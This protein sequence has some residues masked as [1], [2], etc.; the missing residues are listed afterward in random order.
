MSRRSNAGSA[1]LFR[2]ARLPAALTSHRF[3]DLTI[4]SD[5]PLPE[6]PPAAPGAS[7]DVVVTHA[8]APLEGA[9]RWIQTWDLVEGTHLGRLDDRYVVGFENLARF[10]VAAAADRV[11]IYPEAGASAFLVRH[12]LTHQILPLVMS[13]RGR[14]VLHA[15]A[16]S[17]HDRI[18]GFVGRTGA[19]KST[20]AAACASLGAHLVTDDS[21]ILERTGGGWR[22]CPSYPGLRLLPASVALLGGSARGMTNGRGEDDKFLLMP[23]DHPSVFEERTLPLACLFFVSVGAAGA[24]RAAAAGAAAAVQ[25]ASQLFRL[26]IEDTSESRRLFDVVTTIANDVTIADLPLRHGREHLLIAARGILDSLSR[27][28][29]NTGHGV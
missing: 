17:W 10:V 27:S 28:A 12:V 18:V 29:H 14:C 8:G 3:A 2:E 15:S 26:D 5:R 13:R 19:G 20:M 23:G 9:I 22:A 16:V 7:A 25:L 4:A 6:L 11:T 24:R 21:L 1:R